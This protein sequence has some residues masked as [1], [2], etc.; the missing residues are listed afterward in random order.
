V[1]E[2]N[3]VTE[4]VDSTST[5][6]ALIVPTTAGFQPIESTLS[7]AGDGPAAA[8]ARRAELALSLEDRA[9]KERQSCQI[10]NGK[11]VFSPAIY[12]KAVTCA[13]LVLVV[14]TKLYTVTA[15]STVTI[16]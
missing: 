13:G 12:P 10:V 5:T 11:P 16:T 15:A 6:P 14:S 1:T 2:T 9:S 8:P 4:T 3:T 7:G